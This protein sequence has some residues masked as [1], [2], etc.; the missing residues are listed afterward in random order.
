M[1]LLIEKTGIEQRKGLFLGNIVKNQG[2][3]ISWPMK[4]NMNQEFG[5]ILRRLCFGDK[6][7]YYPSIMNNYSFYHEHVTPFLGLFL[8]VTYYFQLKL[9]SQFGPSWDQCNKE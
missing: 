4:A 3:L 8:W 5:N 6:M 9:L 1:T 2:K 7:N